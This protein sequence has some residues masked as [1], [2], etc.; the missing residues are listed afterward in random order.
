MKTPCGQLFRVACKKVDKSR[1]LLAVRDVANELAYRNR[2]LLRR[3]R[4]NKQLR[5][6]ESV[7]DEYGAGAMALEAAHDRTIFSGKPGMIHLMLDG[8]HYLNTFVLVQCHHCENNC[9]IL[10]GQFVSAPCGAPTECAAPARPCRR[11][12]PQAA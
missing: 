1:R 8:E 6:W 3:L 4:A 12:L 11:Q 7:L 2:A 5:S 10:M 9:G